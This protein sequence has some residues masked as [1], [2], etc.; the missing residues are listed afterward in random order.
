AAVAASPAGEE[1]AGGDAKVH[2]AGARV[3]VDLRQVLLVGGDL[4]PVE[5]GA[6]TQVQREG[7]EDAGD[8]A[9]S[10]EARV[11]ASAAAPR[12]LAG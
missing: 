4:P 5:P 1:A 7:A 11:G 9:R 3:A 8:D 10:D 2:G 12:A 6:E